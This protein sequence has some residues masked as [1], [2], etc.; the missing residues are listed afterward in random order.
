MDGQ[1]QNGCFHK[2]NALFIN[3]ME[4]A[5][6]V[7]M[8]NIHLATS[9]MRLQTLHSSAVHCKDQLCKTAGETQAV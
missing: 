4:S 2:Q 8:A 1:R 5:L 7:K 6:L 9:V 3:F